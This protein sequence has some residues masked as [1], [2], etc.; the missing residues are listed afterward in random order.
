MNQELDIRDV[1]IENLQKQVMVEQSRRMQTESEQ[2][3]ISGFGGVKDNNIADLQLNLREELDKMYHLL[4][5]HELKLLP[6][7]T[8]KW[9]EPTDDRMIIFSTYGVKQ[10]M[11]I[12][13]NCLNKNIL[14]SRFDDKTIKWKIRDFGIELADLLLTRAEYFFFYPKPEE[15]Y[16]KYAPIV[17]NQRLNISD[18]ELYK[19]CVSWS[20]QELDNKIAHIPMMVNLIVNSVD[21]TYRRALDGE[22]KRTLRQIIHVSQNVTSGPGMP[23]QD[24]K[25]SNGGWRK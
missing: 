20:N 16:D 3:Q 1:Q 4:S 24:I 23:Y 22:E 8:E 10:I 6:D 2:S 11:S 21:A 7:K 5:G 13:Y 18:V 17:K 9:V 19:K 12:L 15:L 14:L 25:G